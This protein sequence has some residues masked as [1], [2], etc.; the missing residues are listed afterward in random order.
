V[1]DLT[2][3]IYPAPLAAPFDALAERARRAE[4]MGFDSLW[5]PDQ[6]PMAYPQIIEYEAW[7]LLGALARETARIRLGTLV[8]PVTLRHPLVLA[9]AVSTVDHASA[10][11]V[12]LGLGVGGDAAD[13]AGLGLEG[14]RP[15]ELVDRLEDQL[16]IV[17]ALLRGQHVTHREGSHRLV[18][19][20]IEPPVQQ[21]RPPLLV[22]A[23][24]P[25]TLALAARHADIWNSM[26][27][28]PLHGP[29]ISPDDAL[30]A[31]R[32][33]VE[34]LETACAAA[35]RDPATLRRS[36]FAWR[37]GVWSAA[38]AFA[39]WV[40]RYRELGFSDFIAWWPSLRSERHEEQEAVLQHVATEVI[41]GLR[42]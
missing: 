23:Q 14:L 17:D 15:G 21:P 34:T 12:T 38:D 30:A 3:G 13:L 7:S 16:V 5:V 31:T 25:R 42:R 22:A 8:T 11:R 4:A 6:T 41:P 26:G 32:R 9:M 40:E 1:S 37:A 39:E 27:G 29:R 28:Q 35:G 18:D 19:A 2:F 10:G 33:Q 24:G 20:F 36:V